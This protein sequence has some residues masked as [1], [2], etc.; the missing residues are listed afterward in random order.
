MTK[1]TADM[2][3]EQIEAAAWELA[4]KL[5]ADAS[6]RFGRVQRGLKWVNGIVNEG[7][8]KSPEDYISV[9]REDVLTRIDELRKAAAEQAAEAA[10][11]E[12]LAAQRANA[13]ARVVV[14]AGRHNVGDTLNGHTITGLGRPWVPNADQFS[15]YGIDPSA[16]LI[17]YAY[18]D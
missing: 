3:D 1:I 14:V 18:F 13:P 4:A 12:T 10:K 11:A 8:H 2:T 16:S 7:I 5:A 15:A 9:C 6:E 17:Q